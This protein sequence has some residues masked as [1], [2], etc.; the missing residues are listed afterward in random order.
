MENDEVW[1]MVDRDEVPKVGSFLLVKW[2]NINP[3]TGKVSY[4]DK[5]MIMSNPENG[6]DILMCDGYKWY[7]ENAYMWRYYD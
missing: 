3:V 4:E 7:Y 1:Y 5:P 6:K 2:R